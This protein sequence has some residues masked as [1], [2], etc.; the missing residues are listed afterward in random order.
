VDWTVKKPFGPLALRESLKRAFRENSKR[1]SGLWVFGGPEIPAEAASVTGWSEIG[2]GR[3]V[4]QFRQ[5]LS[6]GKAETLGAILIDSRL[7]AE[8]PELAQECAWLRK[9][10]LGQRLSWIV[11]SREISEL[12]AL[13]LVGRYFLETPVSGS[14]WGAAFGQAWAYHCGQA[15]SE[16]EIQVIRSQL[17]KGMLKEASRQ[18][19]RALGEASLQSELYCLGAVIVLREGRTDQALAHLEK[20]RRLNPCSPKIYIQAIRAAGISRK[21]RA[22]WLEQ[23]LRFCPSHPELKLLAD[24]NASA[25]APAPTPEAVLSNG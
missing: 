18:V 14:Q 9:T 3:S 7:L 4:A 22:S 8:R 12:R 2:V 21:Q 25:S 13:R 19:Q 24:A 17:A 16:F 11:L 6:A 10:P 1:R 5:W 20:A 15:E 23:G